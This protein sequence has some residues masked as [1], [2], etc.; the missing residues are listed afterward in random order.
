MNLL[1][2]FLKIKKKAKQ[3]IKKPTKSGP[4][5]EMKLKI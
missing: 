3:K 2:F 5:N 1:V 4:K